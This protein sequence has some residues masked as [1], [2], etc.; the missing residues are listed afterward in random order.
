MNRCNDCNT[1]L[2]RTLA[3]NQI[4][5][6]FSPGPGLIPQSRVARVQIPWIQCDTIRKKRVQRRL[7]S[8]DQ[9]YLEHV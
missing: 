8:C 9:L 3:Y 5:V 2:N 4:E 1:E 6:V 7:K